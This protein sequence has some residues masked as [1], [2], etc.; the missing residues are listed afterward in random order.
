[1]DVKD[2]VGKTITS[3]TLMKLEDYDDT[4][5]LKLEFSDG[6]ECCVVASYGGYTGE[7]ED[8]YPARVL[9]DEVRPDL[10]PV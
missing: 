3:A 7:S 2:L 10:V 6:S 1:M 8:E 5:W 9:L 4:A